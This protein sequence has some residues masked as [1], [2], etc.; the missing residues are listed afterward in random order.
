M[1]AG[2]SVVNVLS[3]DVEEYFHAEEVQNTSW[4]DQLA[5]AASR[6]ETQV[7]VVLGILARHG[8]KATFFI[9]GEVAEKHPG[10]IQE[11][12]DSG[13]EIGCHSYSHRLIYGLTPDEFRTDTERAVK[14]ITDACG[15]T[16]RAYRAPSYS[17]TGASMWALE[18]LVKCGFTYDSS[19]YPV[20]HDRYGIPGFGR[21][22]QVIHTP[23][24]PIC[25][26][27]IATVRLSSRQT[28]PVGGGG[29]LRLLPYCYTAA[30]LRRINHEEHEASCI[31]FHPWELDPDQ[32]R[33]ARGAIARLRTYTGLKGMKGKIERLLTDF[34]FAPL[35]QVY[36]ID[37][38]A[39]QSAEGVL[40]SCPGTR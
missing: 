30:G 37:F 3:V 12:A 21:H 36:P 15:K 27:P 34:R 16:P 24:G 18:I 22:A 6:V 7:R 5:S 35:T 26:V 8:V 17:I 32:P 29:Y 9:V 13:H 1:I 31:Y 40:R 20:V 14:A 4:K 2:G 19:I 33:L 23:E 10:L 28:V 38:Q 11:I 39:E 25:E